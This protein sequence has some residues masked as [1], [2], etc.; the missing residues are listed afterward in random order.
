MSS[1]AIYS[2]A[3]YKIAKAHV[4]L[5]PGVRATRQIYRGQ[6]WIVLED[7]YTHR[8]FRV[9]TEAYAFLQTLDLNRTIDEAWQAYLNDHPQHAPGQ[10]E[11]VQL[12]SQLHVSNLLCFLDAADNIEIHERVRQYKRKELTSKLLSF[13][14]FR[15]PLWNPDPFLNRLDVWVR[16]LP[17]W[18]LTLVWSAVVLVGLGAAITRWDQVS[19]NTQGAFAW[20]N[21]PWLYLCLAGMKIVHELCHGM[22][23]KRLGGHVHTVGVM[24][25]VTT[26]LPYI[27][28]TASWAFPNKWHRV[29]VSL[30]G[31]MADLF[32]AALGALVWANTGPGLLNSLAFNV[33]LIGSVSSLLFNGN[34][35]LRFD[36]YYALADA[37]DIPNFYQKAQQYWV[38]LADRYLLGSHAAVTPVDVPSERKWL[39]MYTPLSFFYRLLVSYAIVLFVMDLWLGLGLIMLGLTL[40]TLVAMP[41]WKAIKHVLGP[42][43][44]AH[45]W[46][47][48]GVSGALVLV[49]ALGLFAIPFPYSLNAQGVMQYGRYTVLYAPMDA[50]LEK[51]VLGNGQ[52]VQ[53]GTP[54][55]WMDR[56]Q[57]EFEL[58]QTELERDELLAM[59]RQAM[60]NR[61]P[62]RA[63]LQ[64]NIESKHNRIRELQLRL[65]CL[66][67]EAKHD[68]HYV[69]LEGRERIGAWV[70]MGTELGHVLDT[71]SGFQFVAV[72]PQESARELFGATLGSL[73]L[74]LAGQA[75]QT[76]TLNKMSVLPY[77]RQKLPSAALGWHGGGDIAT[78]QD[79]SHGEKASEEFYEIRLPVDTRDTAHT[80]LVHGQKGTLNIELPSRTLYER[81]SQ[82]L[83]QLVQ[84]RYRLG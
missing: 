41:L 80:V 65:K 46:R 8:F 55:M 61:Q 83:R 59:E 19:D 17:P 12:L 84:K 60:F 58:E 25:L 35:L 37:L 52:H 48:I 16:K 5:L 15:I 29:L 43:V 70:P 7:A 10:E 64:E 1:G 9:T 69:T 56:T 79:D 3:W 27:D 57:V 13:L 6:P 40:G 68:G 73:R 63:P 75:D 77:Q 71:S 76:F 66:T 49:F 18:L 82:S 34:P 32:M 67:I 4:C 11:V 28:T 72:I 74:R 21:L 14:Y 50:K 47:A 36:A 53:A 30:A 54:L 38:Y 22:V 23:C 24:L 33:M 31:M 42:K 44:Q 78:T 39:M 62:D 26:P 81:I 2:D 45:R 51:A 20:A